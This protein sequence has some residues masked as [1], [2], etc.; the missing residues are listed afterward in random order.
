M[1]RAVSLFLYGSQDKYHELRKRSVCHTF[2]N[3]DEIHDFISLEN[4]GNHVLKKE[5]YCLDMQKDKTFG[6]SIECMALSQTYKIN[7][8][9][10]FLDK[11]AKLVNDYITLHNKPL[12]FSNTTFLQSINILFSGQPNSG[13]FDLLEEILCFD[14]SLCSNPSE[15]T[16]VPFINCSLCNKSFKNNTGLNI[17]KSK[18]HQKVNQD[19]TSESTQPSAHSDQFKIKCNQC[20]KICKNE[21]G[22]SQHLKI[23]HKANSTHNLYSSPNV[24][25]FSSDSNLV[26]NFLSSLRSGTPILKRIPKSARP[27][28][29]EE[30][31]SLLNNCVSKNDFHSW[32]LL[33]TFAYAVLKVPEK[34]KQNKSK[35]LTTLVKMNL[36]FWNNNKILPINDFVATFVLKDA[37]SMKINTQKNENIIKKVESKISDG[38]ISGAIRLLCSEDTLA[39]N[40]ECT[41]KKLLEKHPEHEKIQLFLDKS[42]EEN[43]FNTN[44]LSIKKAISSFKP[45]SAGGLDALRPQHLKDLVSDELGTFSSNLLL[46]VSS[47]MDSVLDGSIPEIIRPIFYGASLCA[48]NKKDGGIRPIA[49]GLCFRRLVAK[50]ICSS[51]N[52]LLGTFFFVLINWVLVLKMVAKS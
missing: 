17:H 18:V 25:S 36:S 14:D 28:I 6:T 33:L 42:L 16:K 23:K 4:F 29:S 51:I 43:N 30:L 50:I 37:K 8:N 10:Y 27:C 5:E 34:T 39:P 2:E 15:N 44:I 49:V 47:F 13:H 12:V 46:A 31:T 20:E 3:W 11:S 19:I 7:F 40:N 45:G 48:L 35:S 41:L 24:K 22:L 26:T 21:R 52:D 32:F 9:I 38:D 1:F